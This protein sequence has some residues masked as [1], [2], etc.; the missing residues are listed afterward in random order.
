MAA[1][2]DLL[3]A[4]AASRGLTDFVP[5]ADGCAGLQ[6][7]GGDRVD[8]RVDGDRIYIYA[9]LG[10]V[11]PSHEELVLTALLA[12]NRNGALGEGPV[13]SLDPTLGDIILCREV[14]ARTTD[15]AGL[16]QVIMTVKQEL[17]SWRQ[18]LHDIDSAP[19]GQ[20]EARLRPESPHGM[21]RG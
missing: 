21:I 8:F 2:L 15:P 19:A 10:Q 9:S 17:D 12:V 20:G 11:P 3:T 13:F 1:A 7:D 18:R 14:D 16:M 5:D 4:F 6:I